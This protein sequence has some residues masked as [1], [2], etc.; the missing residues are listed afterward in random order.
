M[1]FF[2]MWYER[3]TED[4]KE[5]VKMLIKEGR[6]GF[7]NAGWSMHDEACPHFEDMINNMLKGHQFLLKE[8]GYKPRVGWHIDPFGHSNA[9]PRLFADM[10]LEAWIFARIDHA[11]HEQREK[12]KAMNYLWRP[13]AKH[14]GNQ[15]QIF[16][17]VMRDHYGWPQG[18]GMDERTDAGAFVTN[19]KL[20]TF[21]ADEKTKLLQKY[22][23]EMSTNYI[24]NQMLIPFGNDFSFANAKMCFQEMDRLISY[25]NEHNTANI[26]LLYSTPNA[27]ID[28]LY[29]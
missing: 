29:K 27:Y 18:F 20:D 16:T 1:K 25:F 14:F 4:L 22:I 21:N 2:S 13:F 28:S 24:G 9:N 26:T 17:G 11:D 5:K 19:E 7:V 8:F 10:G 12:D 15:K 3:Q 6:L 23:N